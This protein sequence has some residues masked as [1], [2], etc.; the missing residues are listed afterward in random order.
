MEKLLAALDTALD[1]TERALL[2]G[3][4]EPPGYRLPAGLAGRQA[5]REQVKAGL[6]QLAADGRHHYHPI[7]PEARRMKV[8]GVNRFAYNAQAVVDSQEG[9]IVA[10]EAGRQETDAGQLVPMI[11]PARDTLGVAGQQTTTLADTGYGAGADL[12]AAQEKHLPVLVPPAEG[13]PA[14]DNPY[15][16]PHFYYDPPAQTVTCPQSHRLD[17]EGHTTK[18]GQRVERYRCHCQDCPVRA[19]C[20]HDPKGRQIEVWPHTAV[21]QTLRAELQTPSGQALY[22]QR[23]L[24][25][26]RR[27]GQIKQHDGFRRWTVGG[28]KPCAPNG[29]GSVRP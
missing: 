21:V 23:S 13:K 22:Q 24:L 1:Q 29:L 3:N 18:A 12:Q 17:Y 5:L 28:W 27:F 16:S 19:Q 4:Q 8:G 9:V 6:A 25:I 15:A 11:E 2:Q 26:E 7:E 10:C 14:H 20:T